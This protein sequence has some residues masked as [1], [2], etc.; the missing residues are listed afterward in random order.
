MSNPSANSPRRIGILGGTGF[1]GRALRERLLKD[2]H[3]VKVLTRD[4]AP[5]ALTAAQPYI[6]LAEGDPRDDGF[7]REALADCDVAINLVGIL[8]E[9]GHDGSEFR[10][11]H[12]ELPRRFARISRELGVQ[13][14]LHMSSLGA[15]PA[16]PSHYLRSKGEG[17]SALRLELGEALPWTIFCPSVIFGRD[18]SF[19][20][21]FA[22]LLKFMPGIF[23]LACPQARMAPVHVA[24]VAEAFARSVNDPAT[25]FQRYEICGPR[26]YEL[27]TLVEYIGRTSGHSRLV[28]GLPDWMAR[29]QAGVLE[30]VPGKPFSRDNYRS[31]QI[32][33]VCS[34]SQPGLSDLGITPTAMEDV[35]PGYLS[36]KT[37]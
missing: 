22:G 35:A 30:F 10:E 26:D 32:D 14:V 36:G 33:S 8:N 6:E 23:P 18:D 11:V 37:S 3:S 20:N 1:V 29:L 7:L 21:R 15:D 4:A 28:L 34:A 27:K 5:H 24:D 13:R 9:R 31:L 2:R 12:T 25:H 17:A 16:A 19:T